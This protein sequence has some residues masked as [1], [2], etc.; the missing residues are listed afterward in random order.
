VGDFGFDWF[1]SFALLHRVSVILIADFFLKFSS[2]L[3]FL[4]LGS[5]QSVTEITTTG[6]FGGIVLLVL[7]ADN[8]AVLVMPNVKIRMET[9]HS[10]SPLCLH[11][12]LGESFTFGRTYRVHFHVIR[13][14]LHAVV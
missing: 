4:P 10:I 8:S 12:F 5:I 13:T 14:V 7:R 11:D 9:Q 3:F 6:I 2:D 1:I